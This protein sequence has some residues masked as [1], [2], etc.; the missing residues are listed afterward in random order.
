MNGVVGLPNL[1]HQI[2][3]LPNGARGSV[4]DE[5]PTPGIRLAQPLFGKCLDGS[6]NSR[7]VHAK[8]PRQLTVSRQLVARLQGSFQDRIFNLFYDLFV[9]PRGSN[10]LVH[11]PL[12]KPG[13]R[14]ACVRLTHAGCRSVDIVRPK[15]CIRAAQRQAGRLCQW[16]TLEYQMDHW[17]DHYT[18]PG[19]SLVK[20]DS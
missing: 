20:R 1:E 3:R 17:S 5:R 11:Q 13:V 2:K 14:S 10:R 15:K 19:S 9:E 7:P 6:P 12:P 8:T 18:A 16:I 4:G